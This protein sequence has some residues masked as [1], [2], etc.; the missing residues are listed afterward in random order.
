MLG[1]LEK[2]E[3]ITYLK[4]L[5]RRL[6]E[7]TDAEQSISLGLQLGAWFQSLLC[8]FLAE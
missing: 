7:I 5:L 4:G 2:P 3:S 1:E 8:L 6:N